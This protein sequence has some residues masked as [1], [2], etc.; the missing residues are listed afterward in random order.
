MIINLMGT[1]SNGDIT[2]KSRDYGVALRN[3]HANTCVFGSLALYLFLRYQS[4]LWPDFSTSANWYRTKLF[5]VRG[6]PTKEIEYVD[7]NKEIKEL[8]TEAGI[9]TSKVTHIGRNGGLGMLGII[10]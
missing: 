6:N 2:G 4:S 8:L 9:Q 3:R 1:K 5:C 7:H 10:V